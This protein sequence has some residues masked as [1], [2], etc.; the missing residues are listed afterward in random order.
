LL[1]EYGMV[2][3]LVVLAAYY[4]VATVA[5]QHPE[6][7]AG[8]AAV[9]REL[10]GRLPRGAR[11]L[12]VAGEGQLEAEFAQSAARRLADAG[13]EVVSKVQGRPLDARAA[14]QQ[15]ANRNGKIDAVAASS[16]AA[17][18]SVL[19]DIGRRFPTLGDVPVSTPH[20]YRWPNFLMASNLL[21][22]ANQ[23]AIIAIMAI[24]MTMV[25]IT[26]GIDL[27]VGS[28]LAL[29]AV[30]A[31][32]LIRQFTGAE[33]AGTA[34]MVLCCAA[35][36]LLCTLVGLGSGMFVATFALPPFIVTLSVMLLAS[37]LARELAKDES[38]YELPGRFV[39]LG[40]EASIAG[41]PNAVVL[42]VVLYLAAHIL[43]SRMTLGRYIYAVG[44]N[45]QAARLSGVRVERILLF[46]Y[47]VS[48]ALAG[49]GG[50]IMASQLKSGSP[51]Y[52]DKY[53]M[54]VIAAVVVGGAS[55]SGGQGKIFGT[56]IGAFIIAVIQNGM[57]LTGVGSR[58]QLIV[59]GAVI[60]G[61]VLFDR[62][63]KHGLVALRRVF[64]YWLS[65]KTVPSLED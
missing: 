61:A 1:S 62:I 52:G 20:S 19:E 4:S 37:G 63:K 3:V 34:G 56:L 17:S 40:R 58:S 23:I 49:L 28:L 29:S 2:L 38:I 32:L 22:I 18:W 48:G 57:N 27:S 12:V 53:E 51:I 10:A 64:S 47:C 15:I 44:G 14:L 8:G 65:D 33:D 39:W 30:T 43:M 35:A 45:A 50:V 59:L 25:I 21:N 54:Y 60:L 46:V 7:A 26:G 36:I 11:V 41:L 13:I 5:D 9:A 16:I 42:M 6:G 24:G 31:T 55:L